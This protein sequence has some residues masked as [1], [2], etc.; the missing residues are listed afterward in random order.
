[1]AENEAM[2]HF[3]FFSG[4][5][6]QFRIHCEMI[7]YIQYRDFLVYDPFV[8]NSYKQR[9]EVDGLPCIAD[10]WPCLL[11]FSLSFFSLSRS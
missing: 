7:Y 4:A 6:D 9:L 2:L 11:S 10:M 8:S 1:M 5:P 3:L